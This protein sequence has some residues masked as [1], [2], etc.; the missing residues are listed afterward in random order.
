MRV[1]RHVDF[2]N[3]SAIAF[4]KWFLVV[5]QNNFFVE[6]L[7]KLSVVVND[8]WRF[9]LMHSGDGTTLLNLVLPVL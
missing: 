9:S 7:D 6:L 5:F 2:S 3:S 4:C 8:R 1:L